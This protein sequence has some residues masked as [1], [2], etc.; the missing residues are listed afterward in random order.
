MGEEGGEGP[1][2]GGSWGSAAGAARKVG[3]AFPVFL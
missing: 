1:V 3:E 2:A